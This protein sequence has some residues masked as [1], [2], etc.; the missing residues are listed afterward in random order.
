MCGTHPKPAHQARD[1]TLI[2]AEWAAEV[3]DALL[4]CD[5]ACSPGAPDSVARPAADPITYP[6]SLCRYVA[7]SFRLLRVHL[8]R[9]HG[10]TAAQR[11]CAQRFRR[12][13]HSVDGMPTCR[14]C[15]RPLPVGPRY[16]RTSTRGSA[17]AWTPSRAK[18][19]SLLGPTALPTRRSVLSHILISV[20]LRH[21]RSTPA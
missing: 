6:C 18:L 21:N 10:Q 16:G 17:P 12:E 20:Y 2:S 19:R 4:A 3:Q 13:S 1:L 15:G 14:L 11:Y 5:A 7:P 9:V 8:S